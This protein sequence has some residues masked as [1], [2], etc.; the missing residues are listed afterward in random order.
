V[1]RN[2]G[3]LAVNGRNNFADASFSVA[4]KFQDLQAGG[5]G[6]GLQDFSLQCEKSFLHGDTSMYL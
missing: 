6:Q 2:I 3:L 4:K 5:L 1:A